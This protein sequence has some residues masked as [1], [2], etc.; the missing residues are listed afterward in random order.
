MYSS[1]SN[2][3]SFPDENSRCVLSKSKIGCAIIITGPSA[4]TF[5]NG[6]EDRRRNP[7]SDRPSE[8]RVS[9]LFLLMRQ[10]LVVLLL[11]CL[12]HTSAF[13]VVSSTPTKL[14]ILFPESKLVIAPSFS[15]RKAKFTTRTFA[16][17]TQEVSAA[18]ANTCE[19]CGAEFSSRNAIFRHLRSS[20]D[21]FNLANDVDKLVKK[22]RKVAIQFGYHRHGEEHNETEE[23][24]ASLLSSA[25]SRSLHAMH[26]SAGAI[27][28]K[29][30]SVTS[31]VSAWRISPVGSSAFAN[32]LGIDYSYSEPDYVDTEE[33]VS[34]MQEIVD[35]AETDHNDNSVQ[36]LG[37]EQLAVSTKFHAE[38]SCTQQAYHYMLP[39]RWLNDGEEAEEW[40]REIN[41]QET[42]I[43]SSG[44]QGRARDG[45]TPVALVRLKE[46]LKQAESR[47][48]SNKVL[49][50]GPD[51]AMVAASF[52]SSPGRFGKLWQ[53]ERRCW[54]NFCDPTLKATPSNEFVWGTVDRARVTGFE[55]NKEHAFAVI[56]LRGDSFV[57]EQISRILACVVAIA[58]GW[59]PPTFFEVA[60][61]PNV[62]IE[63]PIS[64]QNR[65][66]FDSA[67][68]HFIE[69]VLGAN[70]FGSKRSCYSRSTWLKSLQSRMLQNVH[71]AEES[72]W[73]NELKDVIAPQIRLQIY[74]IAVEHA[75]AESEK[76]RSTHSGT[77]IDRAYSEAPVLYHETLSLLKEIHAASEWPSTPVSRSRVIRSAGSGNT[78]EH[79][80]GI[81]SSFT[82]KSVQAGSFVLLNHSVAA[83]TL[84]ALNKLFSDLALSVF[85]LETKLAEVAIGNEGVR[86]PSTHC[87]VNRNAGFAP[88]TDNGR[89]QAPTMTV[90]LGDFNGG[91]LII[92][93]RSHDVRYSPLEYDGW[94]E[95]HSTASFEGERFSLTW[96]TPEQSYAG[97]ADQEDRAQR[98]VK[99]HRKMLPSYPSL[100]FR[101]NSTDAL[102]V[103]E[104]LD[105]SGKGCAYEQGNFSLRG[106]RCVIDIGAHIGVFTRYVL[107]LGCE[108][109]I[110]Y[111]PESQNIE[112][113]RQN[114]QPT[115]IPRE[116]QVEIHEL[117][118]AHGCRTT[119]AFVH[120]TS[121]NDGTLNTWRHSLEEYSNYAESKQ[122]DEAGLTRSQVQ[123]R[124][125][126]G[127]DGAL[128]EGITAVKLDCEG[129]ELDILLSEEAALKVSWLD[130]THLVFEWSFT[131]E[132]R[133]AQFHRAVSNLQCAGF[134]V[135][136][137][138]Q[139][140]T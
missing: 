126:F 59:L 12:Q 79:T 83:E 42:A 56:E 131:K 43:K 15:N 91:D 38:R 51:E 6:N 10:Y 133:V 57:P 114:A 74:L 140:G 27:E 81:V 108:R 117:A 11:S 61:R 90:T 50:A 85:E 20:N 63:T 96:F 52:V 137:E 26:P 5:D 67:R 58:N 82:G 55:T 16:E 78:A 100:L 69:L 64:P 2:S 103:N 24:I 98:I 123:T 109:V 88:H 75:K 128:H 92:G 31:Q 45:S 102:V 3:T 36:V 39:L 46:A 95:T 120:A 110:A 22:K 71:P 28:I 105:S 94:I 121:R 30:T 54:H 8:A 34:R 118:V 60:T 49:S 37:L 84:P 25:F 80:S 122:L 136:Y 23:S 41:F 72:K 73:L 53:K 87:A 125:M 40:A 101:P 89:G 17:A 33:V 14:P 29:G 116:E 113:L 70:L 112:L 107:G 18:N 19:N 139:G 62:S 13:T 138:G 32:I 129:A 115:L 21:C 93:G 47:N 99:D 124:P 68:F 48:C 134:V 130:V 86:P 119:K 111:E 9:A 127:E 7:M 4:V 106:H 132:R 66:Y 35:S 77:T 76:A 1:E 135:T 97:T 44:H 104:I 65:L